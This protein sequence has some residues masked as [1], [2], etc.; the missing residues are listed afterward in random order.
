M[1]DGADTVELTFVVDDEAG[2]EVEAI[3]ASSVGDG[4]WVLENSPFVAY[5]VSW[6]DVVEARDIDGT[7][8]YVRT[9]KKSGHRTLR[10]IVERAGDAERLVLRPMKKLGCDVEGAGG[11]LFAIDVPPEV[12]IAPVVRALTDAGLTWEHAD[13]TYEALYGD[14]EE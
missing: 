3:P 13:P 11:T 8:R 1:S 14:E 7:L 10:A 2:R 4:T 12:D 5:G 6:Q 9:V